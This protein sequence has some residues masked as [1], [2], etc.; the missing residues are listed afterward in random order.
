[1]RLNKK[2]LVALVLIGIIVL[3]IAIS[4]SGNLENLKILKYA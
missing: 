3:A 4:F 2:Y 1:M